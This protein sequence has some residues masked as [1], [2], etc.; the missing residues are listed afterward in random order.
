MSFCTAS[1]PTK[2]RIL[3]HTKTFPH[4]PISYLSSIS[5][6]PPKHTPNFS[7]M[8]SSSSSS[9]LP[10]TTKASR[11]FLPL[12]DPHQE[13]RGGGGR[14]IFLSFVTWWL[15][16]FCKGVVGP[17]SG[18]CAGRLETA[19][20]TKPARHSLMPKIE[21]PIYHFPGSHTVQQYHDVTAISPPSR[22]LA[23]PRSESRSVP[24]LASRFPL[25]NSILPLGDGHAM[26]CDVM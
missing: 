23:E 22:F 14:L 18:G 8:P 26:R 13:K 12:Q 15:P 24:S 4:S 17:C 21:N 9:S 3:L 25:P 16:T 2:C 1:S 10:I 6:K 20:A 11:T 7:R 5:W 19:T